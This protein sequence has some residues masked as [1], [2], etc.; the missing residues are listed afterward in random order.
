VAPTLATTFLNRKYLIKGWKP[1]LQ[2]KGIPNF[3]YK[4]TTMIQPSIS[5]KAFWDISIDELDF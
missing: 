2:N 5:T 4:A 3:T 1:L